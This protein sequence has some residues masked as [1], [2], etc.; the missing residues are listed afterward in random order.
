MKF[1]DYFSYYSTHV[2]V[3]ARLFIEGKSYGVFPFIVNYRSGED[4]KINEKINVKWMGKVIGERTNR[5]YLIKFDSLEV[6]VS[7]LVF[8]NNINFSY[9]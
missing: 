4:L 8:S 5:Q 1:C 6:P 2:V 9:I 3:F 7:A